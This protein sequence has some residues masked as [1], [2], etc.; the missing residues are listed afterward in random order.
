MVKSNFLTTMALGLRTKAQTL[1]HVQSSGGW[2]NILREPFGGAWQAGV[3]SDAP[4]EVAWDRRPSW[5]ADCPSRAR[6]RSLS[7]PRR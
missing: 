6:G 3:T 1:N 4:R 7:P 2:F 5:T